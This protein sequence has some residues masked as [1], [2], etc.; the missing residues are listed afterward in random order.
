MF[1]QYYALLMVFHKMIMNVIPMK[2]VI[3]KIYR[4]IPC[5]GLLF[6]YCYFHLLLGE[7]EST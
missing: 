7:N 4:V 5:T 2:Y 3:I 1:D 6:R